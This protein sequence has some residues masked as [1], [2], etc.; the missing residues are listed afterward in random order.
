MVL[1]STSAITPSILI[2]SS[3]LNCLLISFGFLLMIKRFE[4]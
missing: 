1:G 2:T 4:F 3:L